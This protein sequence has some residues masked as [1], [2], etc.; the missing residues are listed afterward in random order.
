MSTVKINQKI[1]QFVIKEILPE[2]SGGMAFVVRAAYAKNGHGDVALKISRATNDRFFMNALKAEVEILTR[3]SHPSIVRVVPIMSEIGRTLYYERATELEGYPWYFVMEYLAGGSLRDLLK[4]VN[5]LTVGEACAIS[6]KVAAA[7][8]YV[9]SMG[10]AHNDVKTDNVLFRKVLDKGTPFEP[11]LIDFGIAAKVRRIQQDAGALPWM[12][13]ERLNY[14]RGELAPEFQLDATK[15]DIYAVGVLLYRML[16]TKMP[17]IG[18]TEGSL[19]SAI[20]Y[21]QPEDVRSQNPT[22]PPD[23][24]EMIMTCM[25]KRPEFRPNVSDLV[26]FLNRY[27]RD[28]VVTTG[29]K[30]KWLFGIN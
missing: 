2:G 29:K 8:G 6:S 27:A 30:R 19:T 28:E 9:H 14:V 22:V 15:V 12:S 4:N 24:D 10:Y 5:Q 18:M 17:F 1:S 13:P 26:S 23:L 21:K 11:V 20:L 16:T 7:L 25:S 3:F